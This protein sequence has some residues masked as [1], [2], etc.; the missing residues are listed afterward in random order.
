MSLIAATRQAA[1]RRPVAWFFVLA[2]VA[3]WSWWVPL[4]LQGE[5]VRV[6]DGWPTHLPGLLGPAVAAMVVTALVDGRRGLRGLVGRCLRWRIG[7]RWW[8]VVV[9]TASLVLLA[10][11]VALATD[12]A[13]PQVG[14]FATY[15]GLSPLPPLVVVLVVLVVNGFGEETGW[16]GFAVDRLLRE[17]SLA[18]TAG[19]VAIGWAGWHLPMFWL[20]GSFRDFGP[21]V[22]GWLVGLAAGS[23]VLA[24]MYRQGQRSVLLVA[25]WHTAF[26]FTA[27]TDATGAVVGTLTSILVIGW[28]MTILRREHA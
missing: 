10:P 23:V 19:A 21:L 28:A 16:R 7:W 3:S 13:V 6:G 14:D 2:Y 12:A 17:H 11:V 5:T 1:G 18:R 26:N 15:N 27:A 25:A 9:V 8:A 4:A 20:V 24:W 22:V